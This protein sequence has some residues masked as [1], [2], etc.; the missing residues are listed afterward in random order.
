MAVPA[1][2][3]ERPVRKCGTFTDDLRQMAEWLVGC[4]VTTVAMEST[5]VYWIPVYDVLEKHGLNRAVGESA[6]HEER[7]GQAHGLS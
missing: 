6:E 2:R 5:G 3:D 1:D 7:A 4:N